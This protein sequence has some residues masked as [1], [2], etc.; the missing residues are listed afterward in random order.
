MR[1]PSRSLFRGLWLVAACL[2]PAGP[3]R[4]ESL[5]E[6]IDQTIAAATPNYAALASPLADDAEFLRRITLDLTGTIP[7]SQE[8]RAFLEDVS[9]DK[10]AKLIDR[11]LQSPEHVR[12]MVHLFDTFLM[13]RR[14]TQN[15]PS[16]AWRDYLRASFEANKPWDD[17]A[18][19]I[20]SADDSDPKQRPAARFLLDRAAEPN[21]LVKDVSR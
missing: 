19:E 2:G 16:A 4:A 1:P 17:L 21:L 9:P 18:R 5:H 3:V 20:L 12:H 11:L 10:R 6:R 8:A 15:V 7:T 14:A 13:E